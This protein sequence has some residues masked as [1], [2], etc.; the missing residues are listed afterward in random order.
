VASLL[1]HA[2]VAS[3]LRWLRC[4]CCLIQTVALLTGCTSLV[5]ASHNCGD[6]TAAVT[7]LLLLPHTIVALLTGCTSLVTASHNCGDCTAAVTALLLLPHTIA[8][9]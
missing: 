7:A 5:T 8:D 4:C 9:L 2:A 6:C 3:L 1:Y